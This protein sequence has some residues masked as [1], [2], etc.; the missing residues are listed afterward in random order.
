MAK[1]IGQKDKKIENSQDIFFLCYYVVF[2]DLIILDY[3]YPTTL[4]AR[5]QR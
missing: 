3:S 1:R 2:M 5:R 4:L